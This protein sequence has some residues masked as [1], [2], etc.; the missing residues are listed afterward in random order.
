MKERDQEWIER[1]LAGELS[2]EEIVRLNNRMVVDPT[3]KSEIELAQLALLSLRLSNRERLRTRL[4]SKDQI[5]K[6]RIPLF[7]I[8]LLT[9]GLIVSLIIWNYRK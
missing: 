8:G 6:L 3:F 1:Y 4:K 9:L 5:E 7:I 2:E